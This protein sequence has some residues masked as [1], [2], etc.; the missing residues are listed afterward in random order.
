MNDKNQSKRTLEETIDYISEETN[1]LKLIKDNDIAVIDQ[2]LNVQHYQKGDDRRGLIVDAKQ[3]EI[4][5]TTKILID[6]KQGE[7]TINQVYDSLYEIGKE[8]SIKIIMFTGGHNDN[9]LNIPIADEYAVNGLI[10]NLQQSNVKIILCSINNGK[11]KIEDH[12]IYDYWK[13]IDKTAEALIP[14]KEQL[15]A[16]TFWSVYFDSFND[17][18]YKSW[19]AYEGPYVDLNDLG[20]TIFIDNIVKGRIELYW[21]E[22]GLRYEINEDGIFDAYLEKAIDIELPTL[23]QRYGTNSVEF[24]NFTG[25]VKYSNTPFSWLYTASPRQITEFARKLHTDAWDLHWQ[26]EAIVEKM[27]EPA[28]EAV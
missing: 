6:L 7:P 14:T 21:D 10:D 13:Q 17:G 18:F 26:M 8:C 24:K 2:I 19:E 12:H 22:D 15:M 27:F 5:G 20:F 28:I 16:E 25:Y 4:E 11:L 9:D 1:L 3:R 23:Q